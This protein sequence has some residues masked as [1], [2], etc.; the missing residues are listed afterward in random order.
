MQQLTDHPTFRNKRILVVVAHP[1]DECLYFYGGLKSLSEFSHIT[2]LSATYSR[3]SHRARELRSA[4]DL[5]KIRCQFL[6]IPDFGFDS[7]LPNLE[8]RF[9]AFVQKQNYDMI[10]T[11]PPHGGEKAHPH[12]LQVFLMSLVFS[13]KKNLKFGFFSECHTSLCEN[14]KSDFLF[15]LKALPLFLLYTI[16]TF[17]LLRWKFKLLWLQELGSNFFIAAIRTI[18]RGLVFRRF[19][20]ETSLVEKK[21]VLQK[22]SSQKSVLQSYKSSSSDREYLFFLKTYD[23]TRKLKFHLEDEDFMTTYY[24]HNQSIRTSVHFQ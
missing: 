7:L 19:E 2:V 12:H 18:F 23:P 24:G 21:K 9:E 3:W 15:K 14:M 10:I 5:M 1:D 16:Q 13:L 17:F 4:C 6:E 20:I 11:H 22:Y 8:Q